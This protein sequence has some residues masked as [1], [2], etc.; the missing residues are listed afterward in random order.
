M[1]PKKI[2]WHYTLVILLGVA[3]YWELGYQTFWQNYHGMYRSPAIW[4]A[5]GLMVCLISFLLIGFKKKEEIINT[6][7]KPIIWLRSLVIFGLFLYG[8]IWC[9]IRLE[10]IFQE[11]PVD[12]KISDII[13]SL[14]MYVQ[15]LLGGETVYKPLPFE[16]YEVNPTYFPLLW[17][18]YIFSEV[19]NIDYRWTAYGVFLLALFFY[20]LK[21]L[22]SET[23]LLEAAV[24]IFVPFYFIYQFIL[25]AKGTFG[26][27]VELLPIGFYLLLTLTIF[28]RNKY[29]MAIGILLCLLS[30]YAF[31][32]WLPL[33]LLIYWIEKGFKNVF[34]VSMY[35]VAGVLLLYVL[36]FLSK[37]WTIL[38]KGLD[39]YEKTAV[40]QWET[41]PWQAPGDKPHHLTKGL[42]LAIHFYDKAEGEV[43]ERLALNR[44]VHIL[45][46]A[47]A[48]FLLGFGYFLF[49]KK[50]LNTKIYLIIGL[51]LYL[52]IFYGFFYVPFAYLFMLPLFMSLAIL[53][54]LPLFRIPASASRDAT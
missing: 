42:S 53:Y 44:K 46:C 52:T 34:T 25:H 36:P 3:V 50:G 15:R 20:N 12:A 49:R 31:T 6:R 24:K 8:A 19:L 13:P 23:G 10:P 54:N 45:A 22:K 39:Y 40:G 2:L 30:R 1:N 47:I 4:M 7:E 29:L 35:V 51:K 48:A 27:A 43:S 16:G 18:P 37:D 26:M 33:Y 38:T 41:Q 28:H 32:F 5:S 14:E 21:L 11:F 17:A 9:G